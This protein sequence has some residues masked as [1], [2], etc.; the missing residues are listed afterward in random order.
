MTSILINSSF[1]NAQIP[2]IV[3]EP[4]NAE[5]KGWYILSHGLTTN[6]SEYLNFYDEISA[7]IAAQGFASIRFDYRGHGE[8]SES[9]NTFNLI[10][11]VSDTISCIKWLQRNKGVSCISLMGTSFGALA[12]ILASYIFPSDFINRIYLLA[13]V[14]DV[15]E[16]YLNPHR[17]ERGK[18]NG[19]SDRLLINNE[20]IELDGLPIFDYKNA[21]EFM[22]F[23]IYKCLENVSNKTTVIHGSHDSIVSAEITEKV[24][25]RYTN[26]TYHKIERMDHGYTDIDDEDGLTQQS[27]S[28]LSKIVDIILGGDCG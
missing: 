2:T 10:N 6:K 14:L 25:S 8:S 20:K 24:V 7:R 21:L 17:P 12:T 26:I 13:P 15:D 23:D 1:D 3:T 28:N 5:I 18:Y 22:F 4:V 27:A 11:N 16:L 19:F 9:I